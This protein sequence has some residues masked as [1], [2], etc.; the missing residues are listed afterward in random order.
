MSGVSGKCEGKSVVRCEGERVGVVDTSRKSFAR[1]NFW[2]ERKGS[3]MG[4]YYAVKTGAV[5][6]IYNTWYESTVRVTHNHAQSHTKPL[7]PNH[8]RICKRLPFL[9]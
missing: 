5:P 6:G 2:K 4:K 8:E 1:R 7:A 9:M 3:K